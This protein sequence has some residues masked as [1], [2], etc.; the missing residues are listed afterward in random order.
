MKASSLVCLLVLLL[1]ATN[2]LSENIDYVS[3]SLT[4]LSRPGDFCLYGNYGLFAARTIESPIGGSHSLAI[5]D[6]D[7]QNAMPISV[8]DIPDN[9]YSSTEVLCYGDFAY[10]FFRSSFYVISLADIHHP[11]V[12]K[13]ITLY[14]VRLASI[15]QGSMLYVAVYDGSFTAYSL[16]VPDSPV[17]IDTISIPNI[18]YDNICAG[19]GFVACEGDSIYIVDTSDPYNIKLSA[20]LAHADSHP[21][22]ANSQIAALGHHLICNTMNVIK[23][24]NLTDPYSPI[25]TS[26]NDLDC[27]DLIH[28][29]E[30]HDNVLW[31]LYYEGTEDDNDVG[32]MAIDLT[33]PSSPVQTYKQSILKGLTPNSSYDFMRI[34]GNRVVFYN[35]YTCMQSAVLN[36]SGFTMS[37]IDI[38]YGS[39]GKIDASRDW[40]VGQNLSL[41]ILGF[42]S[43]KTL[44]PI[45]QIVPETYTYDVLKISGDLLLCAYTF[46]TDNTIQTYYSP[47][48]D[49]Y[50]LENGDKLSS[51][52]FPINEWG[53]YTTTPKSISIYGNNAYLCNGTGGLVCVD[54]S[55]PANPFLRFWI[56]IPFV[57]VNQAAVHENKLF[58]ATTYYNSGSTLYI[59]DI[60]DPNNPV[61]E[62]SISLGMS[63][64]ASGIHC[65]GD[66]LYLLSNRYMKCFRFDGSEIAEQ[67]DYEFYGDGVSTLLPIGEGLIVGGSRQMWVISLKDPLHPV[68]T[69]YQLF[70]P[71]YPDNY[72]SCLFAVQGYKVLV[73]N[74]YSLTCYDA[75]QAVLM[76]SADLEPVTGELRIF[77]N[78]GKDSVYATFKSSESGTGMIN[79][80]NLRG[81]KV[82]SNVISSITEG[83][84]AKVLSLTSRSGSNLPSG[85]YIIQ[86]LTPTQNLS[87]KIVI[88]R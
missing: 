42:S 43:D 77:P 23:V 85:V 76:C 26:S 47:A 37:E 1:S 57:R 73:G 51:F 79:I 70:D 24:Y 71:P 69:G 29:A 75:T 72:S 44:L 30:I 45:N 27:N 34:A 19:D 20:S 86:V 83:V 65:N 88:S 28:R 25:L 49:I 68:Q 67:T 64:N 5:V 15:I 7:S 80:F 18:F 31:S 50:N 3:R 32:I 81:Q 48:L 60:S 58:L 36:G 63:P 41:N 33:N 4:S 56:F 52:P 22:Y 74:G 14:N 59:Y 21:Y 2:L 10:L 39:I 61:Q 13:E 55:D 11:I 16:A 62:N 66:Y 78:P 53:D 46:R 87:S 8:L 38:P 54:I 84:N 40:I 6:F 9:Y 82:V 12:V 35:E 17:E